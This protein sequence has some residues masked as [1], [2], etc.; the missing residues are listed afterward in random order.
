MRFSFTTI[1]F[2]ESDIWERFAPRT[3]PFLSFVSFNFGKFADNYFITF[4][5]QWL[6]FKADSWIQKHPPPRSCPSQTIFFFFFISLKRSGLIESRHP[7]EASQSSSSPSLP[8]CG[9]PERKV[10]KVGLEITEQLLKSP[11][12]KHQWHRLTKI[13][14]FNLPL[15]LSPHQEVHIWSSWRVYLKFYNSKIPSFLN[16]DE[17]SFL[18]DM[19]REEAPERMNNTFVHF[20]P[21]RSYL[22]L[23][24]YA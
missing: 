22:I 5:S 16:P 6:H 7:S 10:K 24:F 18:P 15:C 17:I 8:R 1:S 14:F 2:K 11:H 21:V 13:V 9:S 19:D 20:Q 12:L 3:R 23:L 4:W